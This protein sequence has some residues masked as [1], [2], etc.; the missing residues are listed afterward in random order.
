MK[1]VT[2]NLT[3]TIDDELDEVIYG[4][5]YSHT[6][7]DKGKPFVQVFAGGA[8]I[9]VNDWKDHS[10]IATRDTM[11]RVALHFIKIGKHINDKQQ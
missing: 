11:R 8:W 10:Y 7:N 2:I 3:I 4:G 9:P 6:R 1:P 5:F